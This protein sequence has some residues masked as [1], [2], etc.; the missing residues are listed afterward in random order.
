MADS[1][2]DSGATAA[3][4]SLAKLVNI[5]GL[6]AE[7]ANAVEFSGSGPYF[8]TRYN[9][10]P[11]GAAAMAAAGLA[12]AELWKIKTGR[13]QQV[14][15]EAGAVA[16]ALRGSRYLR[17]N[18]EKPSSDHDKVSGFYR[19]R[20]DRWIYLH[21]N[22]WNLRDANARVLG[23]PANREALERAVATREGEELE[24]AIFQGGGACGFVRSEEEWRALPQAQ[25]VARLP[26]LE[27]TRIG[28]A[29]PSPLPGGDRPLSAVRVLD[30]TRVLAGPTCARTLAEH[31]ADVLRVTRADLADMGMT[32][33]DTGIGKL[34]AHIDLREP[35][36]TQTMR[37]LIS[38][39]DVFS[40]SYRP[41]ALA[42]R[43]LSP[44]ALA[45]IRPGI[46][47]VTLSAWGHEGPWRAR[48][49]YDTVVQSAN[50][51]A[52][53]T[54]NAK[55]EFLPVSAQ[56]YVAGYLLAFGA[57][58][59]LGRRVREGGSWLV[60]VSLAGAGHFIR[61]HGLLDEAVYRSL[62]AELPTD[63]LQKLL[64]AHD[65]PIGRLTHLAPAVQMSQTPPRWARPAVPLGHSPAVWPERRTRLRY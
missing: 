29:P 65:S 48:R 50:G 39:C 13:Q 4:A 58:V 33:F 32:D 60:R 36:G 26:L 62:P 63:E 37:E 15:I 6:P 38:T 53:S 17:V 20:D 23:V 64:I 55:P 49:G 46:V 25:T 10:V 28:E 45:Q 40:Q 16:A 44:E 21:C 19:L 42:G 30:L 35:A 8:P 11:P 41:D 52:Y 24:T 18:G 34:S 61:Q 54:D 59:A 47:Y 56:D 9:I 5:S 22:F 14:K 27:I 3:R 57:M 2:T 31:G 51:M 43:G 12:A 1:R 7:I